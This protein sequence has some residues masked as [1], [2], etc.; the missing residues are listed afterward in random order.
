MTRFAL[1]TA[2]A[3]TVFTG[4]SSPAAAGPITN[5]EECYNAV[6]TWCN[7]TFPDHDCSSPSGLDECDEVFASHSSPLLQLQTRPGD[8]V[9]R[10]RILSTNYQPVERD[11]DRGGRDDDDDDDRGRDRDRGERDSSREPGR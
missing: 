4:L 2:A 6:I 10:L 3:M 7:E 9:A 1:A 5:L 8:P 11:D